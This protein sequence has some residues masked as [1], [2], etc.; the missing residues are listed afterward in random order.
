MAN[1][2]FDGIDSFVYEVIDSNGATAEGT[3]TIT[4]LQREVQILFTTIADVDDS[5]VAGVPSWDAGE[6]LAIGDPNLS[7]EPVGTDGS[8]L[9]YFDLEGFSASNNM[10]VDGL[11]FVSNDLTIGSANSVDLTRGDILFVAETDDV[12]TST[13]SLAITAGDVIAF[14]PDVVGDFSSGTFVHLLDAPGTTQTTGITLTV[15]R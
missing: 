10:T 12:M 8:I 14:H 11:H 5:Q 13:N 4:V 7:F 6:I 1:N 2:N 3:A 9:P 15:K